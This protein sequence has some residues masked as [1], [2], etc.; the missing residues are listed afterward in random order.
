M[1]LTEV[2]KNDIREQ[3]CPGCGTE[4]MISFGSVSM[5]Q[6]VVTEG[7][8]QLSDLKRCSR[9]GSIGI[10]PIPEQKLLEE[11]YEEYVTKIS[12]DDYTD[13]SECSNEEISE[14]SFPSIF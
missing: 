14:E 9:C 11:Y 4:S 10:R 6:S 1:K 12:N 3:R 2:K 8:K 13:E 7:A 5:V